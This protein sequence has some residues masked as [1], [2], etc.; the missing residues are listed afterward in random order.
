MLRSSDN[1][2]VSSHLIHPHT[3]ST[4]E[5]VIVDMED[6]LSSDFQYWLPVVWVRAASDIVNEHALE[7]HALMVSMPPG[8]VCLCY[9]SMFT[10]LKPSQW[11][12]ID[13]YFEDAS[14]ILKEQALEEEVQKMAE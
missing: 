13:D 2:T 3:V 11:W 5:T 7:E 10:S 8:P 14:T 9:Y 4:S 12:V 1:T 6:S